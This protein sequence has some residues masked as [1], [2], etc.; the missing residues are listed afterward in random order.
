MVKDSS[1]DKVKWLETLGKDKVASKGAG[2][3]MFGCSDDKY[4]IKLSHFIDLVRT[5]TLIGIGGVYQSQISDLKQDG[6]R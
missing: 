3:T 4:K 6:T 5:T 2:S 1:H